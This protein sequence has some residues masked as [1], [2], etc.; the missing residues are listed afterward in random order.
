M[1]TLWN[2]SVSIQLSY[3]FNPGVLPFIK[4]G[5]YRERRSKKVAVS[6]PSQAHNFQ[7]WTEKNQYCII[8]DQG[9]KVYRHNISVW[10]DN[11]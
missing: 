3:P 11:T 9:T 1:C 7:S 8:V 10:Q 2:K 4:I 5:T 6:I